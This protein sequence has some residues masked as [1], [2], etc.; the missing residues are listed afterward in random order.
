MYS[1]C[2]KKLNK[3]KK[4]KSKQLETPFPKKSTT[5]K[6]KNQQEK[7]QHLQ[8][9]GGSTVG[10]NLLPRE[11]C[12][13]PEAENELSSLNEHL[14]TPV[15]RLPHWQLDGC[16]IRARISETLYLLPQYARCLQIANLLYTRWA[17]FFFSFSFAD[18]AV[19]PRTSDAPLSCFSVSS[20]SMFAFLSSILS[21]VSARSSLWFGFV[22]KGGLED[23]RLSS[24]RSS[25]IRSDFHSIIHFT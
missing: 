7:Q 8:Q 1:D 13:L 2:K 11:T 6:K 20:D 12:S 15:C 21:V 4:S 24:S 18:S 22:L 25:E 10:S 9:P 5:Q 16:L 3:K 14:K 23:H 19:G 17:F